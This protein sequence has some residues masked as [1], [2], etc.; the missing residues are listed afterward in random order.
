MLTDSVASNRGGI[1]TSREA[2]CTRRPDQR[3]SDS[4]GARRTCIQAPGEKFLWRWRSSEQLWWVLS[5]LGARRVGVTDRQTDIAT[6][7]L[8]W[9]NSAPGIRSNATLLAMSHYP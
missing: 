7:R 6:R 1:S 2:E 3:A 9:V 4:C 8:A 5:V